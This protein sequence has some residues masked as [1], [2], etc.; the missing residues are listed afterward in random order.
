M[1]Y[2]I[3]WAILLVAC[4][5]IAFAFVL[6]STNVVFKTTINKLMLILCLSLLVWSLGLAISVAAANEKI[7]LLGHILAPIGWGPM[8]GLLLHF[9]LLFTGKDKL[10]KRWWIYPLLYIPGILIILGSTVF[11]ALGMYR[12]TVTLSIHGWVP[13]IN[14]DIWDYIYYMYYMVFTVINLAYC[15]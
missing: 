15:L 14:Y 4:A 11:P 3:F 1:D 8:S 9:T 5:G 2:S 7:S 12:D 13:V 6:Y 10:L